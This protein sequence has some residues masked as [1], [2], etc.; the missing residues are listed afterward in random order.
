MDPVSQAAFGAS[1]SQSLAKNKTRQLSVLI[2]GALAGM[3][4]DLDIFINSPTDPLLFLEYHRQFTHA[5]IFIPFGALLC[6]LVFYP[7]A[8]KHLSFAQIYL[9]SFAAYATHGLLDACT[10]YGTQLFW[11]FSNERVAWNTVSIIDPLFTLPVLGLVLFAAFKGRAVYARVAFVYAVI[12]LSLGIFQKQRAED[13]LAVLAD[14]R[15][16]QAVRVQVKPSFANRHLWKTIY[17]YEGRYYV[18]A[19]KLLWNVEYLPGSSIRKLDIKRDFPWLPE[20]SQQAR[21]IERFRWFSDDF[22]AV[23]KRYPNLIMDMRYSFLPNEISPMWGVEVSR[24]QVDAGN[25]DVHVG[26]RMIRNMNPQ[27]RKRFLEML[28]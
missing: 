16:H 15:G 19:V 6:A 4:P 7:F 14:Q 20:D 3:A 10:S 12:F 5:L 28:F 2:I 17:E 23:S 11:P 21:D 18:D 1:F 8:K 24:E 22:L 9:F 26:Y 25:Q 13:A 27:T